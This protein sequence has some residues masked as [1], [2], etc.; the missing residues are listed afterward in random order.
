MFLARMV[1]LIGELHMPAACNTAA[2]ALLTLAVLASSAVA[3]PKAE[4]RP[5][6][7]QKL[8]DCRNAPGDAAQLACY[9]Q[10][11]DALVRAEGA[12]DIVVVDR[13]EARKLRQQAFGLTLPSLSIFEKGEPE[14]ELNSL[15]GQVRTARQDPTG[16]WILQLDSG[17]V[18]T[19][20]DTTPLRMAP[21][22][23]MP[24]L[25]TRAALGSYKMKVGDQHAVKAKRVE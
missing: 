11:T 22:G 14:A 2:I 19:Q 16:R 24:V 6:I 8:A 5:E 23:G 3:Q 4:E 13:K 18:W 21:K 10:M 1:K 9:R 20:V 25:I 15:S 7:I 12:G 17:A